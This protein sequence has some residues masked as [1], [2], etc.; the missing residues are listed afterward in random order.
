MVRGGW[1]CYVPIGTGKPLTTG[2]AMRIL[3]VE[4]EAIV[5][6]ALTLTLEAAGFEV[7]GVAATAEDAIS[8]C[9]AHHPDIAIMDVNLGCGP[10]GVFAARMAF[11]RSGV[12]SIFATANPDLARGAGASCLGVV[13]KPYTSPAIIRAVR[14]AAALPRPTV[15]A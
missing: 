1:A 2:R 3:V 4:D 5:A 7:V 6:F 14:S 13:E 8:A 11:E 10:D 15:A 12:R 9:E